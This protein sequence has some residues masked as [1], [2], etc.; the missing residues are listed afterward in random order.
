VVIW[1]T[2]NEVTER[3]GLGDGFKVAEELA[4]AFRRLDSTRPVSNGICSMW[5]GLDDKGVKGMMQKLMKKAQQAGGLQNLD[6]DE[7]E[8]DF[9]F[10]EAVEAFTNCLDIC[11]YNYLD[12]RYARDGKR[13]PERVILGTESYPNQMD[14]VWDKVE[15]MP[16]VIGDCTWTAWD[17]IG[18]AGLGRSGF[19]KPDDPALAKGPRALSSH[20]VKFPF[21]LANDADFTVNGNL[22]PQGILRKILWGSAETGVFV[23][24]PEHFGMAELVSAWGFNE[25]SPSWSFAGY[26]GKPVKIYVYSAAEMVK[27]F[28]NGEEIGEKAAGK[29][30]RFLA[31]FDA[32]YTPGTLEAVSISGGEEVSR[33]SLVTAGKPA[34]ILLTAET[35]A[36]K[37]D[38]ASLAYVHAALVDENGVLVPDQDLLLTAKLSGDGEETASVLAGFGSDAAVTAESYVSG[39]FTTYHGRCTAV[40]RSGWAKESLTLK[41]TGEGLPDAEIKITVES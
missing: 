18:E 31:E 33:A 14:L 19:F 30:N 39:S 13:Y 25:M 12:Q 5:S 16:F 11:G 34:S 38:G 4:A 7:G 40:I 1:S 28:L 17:Y 37:A 2:G 26:E 29:E 35:E 9:S 8:E 21:R 41:V 24:H 20:T 22:T 6:A 32:V 15:K 3:G 27:L 23:Q 10:E 36:L